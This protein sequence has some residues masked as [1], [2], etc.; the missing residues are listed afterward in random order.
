MPKYV[1]YGI[2]LVIHIIADAM[3]S[4]ENETLAPDPATEIQT[5][6]TLDPFFEEAVYP[7]S[8]GKK[9]IVCD[10]DE[11]I[12]HHDY[13]LLDERVNQKIAT[14]LNWLS[15]RHDVICLTSRCDYLGV[16]LTP[17]GINL[18]ECQNKIELDASQVEKLK[19]INSSYENNII[20]TN[21]FPKGDALLT[22][23][24]M[25]DYQYGQILFVDDQKD[26]VENVVKKLSAD[27]KPIKGYWLQSISVDPVSVDSVNF[28]TTKNIGLPVKSSPC[29]HTAKNT[30]NNIKD[31]IIEENDGDIDIN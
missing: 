30:T 25:T 2:L 5:I 28:D 23:I 3:L 20:Y 13:Y 8:G 26:Q 24:G 6:E 19:N 9:L 16:N 11:T 29:F 15:L 10:I 27:N 22:F 14:I 21:S 17:H 18:T 12:L 4:E 31:N 1:F 7:N